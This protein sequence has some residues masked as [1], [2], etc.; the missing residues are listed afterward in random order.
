MSCARLF[1]VLFL[2]LGPSACKNDVLNCISPGETP[3]F[4][5]IRQH[6]GVCLYDG[7]TGSYCIFSDGNCLTGWRW[8]KYAANDL[9]NQCVD[10]SYLPM[11]AGV[12]ADADNNGARD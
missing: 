5:A 2:L 1:L 6:G 7:V 8:Y 10:P 9:Q 3:C 12:A 4:L 11:D